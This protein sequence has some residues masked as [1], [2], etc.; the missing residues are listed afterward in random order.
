M[1]EPKRWSEAGSDIDPVLRSVV[2]YGQGLGP[3]DAA[4]QRLLR[5]ATRPTPVRPRVF[6]RFAVAVALGMA[7]AFGGAA[8]ASNLNGWFRSP[9][10]RSLQAPPPRAPA[11]AVHRGAS[12]AQHA[13]PP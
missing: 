12:T 7:A 1:N 11:P 13:V 2:R 3:D 9:P 6:R 5:A 8:W 10:Q 4:L